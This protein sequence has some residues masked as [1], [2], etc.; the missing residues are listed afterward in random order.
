MVTEGHH[1][2][3]KQEK[4]PVVW[5]NRKGDS[6]IILAGFGPRSL[7]KDANQEVTLLSC[8]LTSTRVL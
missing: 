2:V 3:S 8:P 1:L 6:S 7:H 4:E 5:L